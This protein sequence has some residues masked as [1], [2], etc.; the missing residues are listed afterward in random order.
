MD[1]IWVSRE[2]GPGPEVQSEVH[3]VVQG[4]HTVHACER[5]VH[6]PYHGTPE[7]RLKLFVT[8]ILCGIDSKREEKKEDPISW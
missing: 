4:S 8:K 3:W 1:R 6:A 5:D 7:G 2:N